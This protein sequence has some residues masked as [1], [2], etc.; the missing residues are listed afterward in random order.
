MLRSSVRST[1]GFP[2]FW[3]CR[4]RISTR[5]VN[6]WQNLA[7][8]EVKFKKSESEGSLYGFSDHPKTTLQ[9]IVVEGRGSL[10]ILCVGGCFS[11]PVTVSHNQCS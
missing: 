3:L 5:F 8:N 2:M 1:V 4:L 11:Q 6:N 7:G 10:R 9:Q